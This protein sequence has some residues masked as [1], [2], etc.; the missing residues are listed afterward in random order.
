MKNALSLIILLTAFS[1]QAASFLGAKKETHRFE[2]SQVTLETTNSYSFYNHGEPTVRFYESLDKVSFG[3]EDSAK[4]H[5]ALKS[6][7][8]TQK[9][10]DSLI[11]KLDTNFF[12]FVDDIIE[13][14]CPTTESCSIAYN[15]DLKKKHIVQGKS[16]PKFHAGLTGDSINAFGASTKAEANTYVKNLQERGSIDD[17]LA[18]N[19]LAPVGDFKLFLANGALAGLLKEAKLCDEFIVHRC[20]T[21]CGRGN[22]SRTSRDTK[23]VGTCQINLKK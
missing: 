15:Q 1:T 23:S 9:Q 4:L 21:Y 10:G 20:G 7:Y 11:A 14:S 18:F 12:A 22:S 2:L 17:V 13:I 6:F 8:K 5:Q 19:E 3:K 16:S